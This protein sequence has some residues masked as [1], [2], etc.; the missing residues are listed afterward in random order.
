[1]RRV[2]FLACAETLPGS[3][4]RRGDAFE[5]DLE[6]AALRPAF[7]DRGMD[8]VEI[9]WRAPLAD[10][11]GLAAVLLGTAWDYQ[12]SAA[13]FVARLDAL[14]ARGVAACNPPEVVRWNLDKRYLRALADAGVTVIPTKW[15]DDPGRAEIVAAMDAF[16]VDRVVVKRQVGAGG[17]GQHSFTRDALPDEGWRMGRAAMIQPF[18]PAIES[19]GEFTFVFIGGQF[20]H[21]VQK[22][23]ATGEYRVQSLFGGAEAAHY[24]SEQDLAT[25]QAV[26]AALPF[27]DLLYARVDMA[28]LPS[29]E[30]AVMECELIEP[31]LYP[32]QGP[33]LG[34]RLAE[35]LVER[36]ELARLQ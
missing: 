21:A 9:D 13:E 34:E 23:P 11:D 35:A 6:V 15:H 16:A 12:D 36:L 18:L 28:R 27:A 33:E 25:A 24:P 1:M 22:R 26:I 2:G 19:E 17:L 3:A 20:S 4:P 5:H 30:P 14:A 8:L 31:Y 29:D 10:F 7:A 32:D